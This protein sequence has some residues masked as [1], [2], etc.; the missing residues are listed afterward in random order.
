[1]I[2]DTAARSGT[3]KFLIFKIRYFFIHKIME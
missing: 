3:D 2:H 1:M